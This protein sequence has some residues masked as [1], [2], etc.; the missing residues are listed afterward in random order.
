MSRVERGTS[1]LPLDGIERLAPA[2]G[3]AVEDLFKGL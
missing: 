3:I 2:F 1:N